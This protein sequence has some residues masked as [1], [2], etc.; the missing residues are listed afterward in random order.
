MFPCFVHRKNGTTCPYVV[1][2]DIYR[3][4]QVQEL[5]TLVTHLM[6]HISELS[7]RVGPRYECPDHPSAN[8]II[9]GNYREVRCAKCNLELEEILV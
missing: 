4:D 9:R 8:W 6:E 5:A 7:L 1:H 2:S 3:P